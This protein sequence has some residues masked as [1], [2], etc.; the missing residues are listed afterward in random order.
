MSDA[1]AQARILAGWIG[2]NALRTTGLLL[3][4][5]VAA[6]LG[7]Y[8]LFVLVHAWWRQRRARSP[9][10]GLEHWGTRLGHP[11]R[12]DETLTDYGARLKQ[13]VP[14][15][16]ALIGAIVEE[17]CQMLYIDPEP[18][19]RQRSLRTKLLR[20]RL[21]VGASTARPSGA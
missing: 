4:G 8:V 6:T 18:R 17:A 11:R 14:A 20:L 21:V 12:L 16:A 13:V 1:D 15:K 3:I 19:A 10:R 9:A 7:S 5:A 2:R